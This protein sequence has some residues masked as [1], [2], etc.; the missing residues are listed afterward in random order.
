MKTPAGLFQF[1]ALLVA[2]AAIVFIF[3]SRQQEDRGAI[4]PVA[5][6]LPMPDFT[7]QD[8][9]SSKWS[10]SDHRGHVVL[11]NFWATWCGP[12][13]MEIPGLMRLSSS[14]TGLDIAG[15]AMD[16]ADDDVRQFVATAGM[17]YAIL[18]PPPS[19]TLTDSIEG[20]PTTFLVDRQG[21]IAK[22]YV[23]AVSERIIRDDVDR[24]LAE[25]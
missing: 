21:R 8:L 12:C 7:M 2:V 24:L 11:V 13:R 9:H 25:P 22:Q 3:S 19:S 15:V 18:L 16:H 5:K 10:L 23:G 1:G 14:R 20:L 6:R 4:V 17:K